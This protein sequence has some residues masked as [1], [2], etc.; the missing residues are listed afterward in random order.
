MEIVRLQ[1]RL[2]V[3]IVSEAPAAKAKNEPQREAWEVER[4]TVNLQLLKAAR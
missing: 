3:A 1:R 2:T 4:L